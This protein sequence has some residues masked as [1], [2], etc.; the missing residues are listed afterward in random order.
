MDLAL[1]MVGGRSERC[2]Q[3]NSRTSNG[4]DIQSTWLDSLSRRL[5]WARGLM[6]PVRQI[7]VLLWPRVTAFVKVRL[8]C[9]LLLVIAAGALTAL[10]PL[11]L[12]VVVDALVGARRHAA[13]MWLLLG[14]Y[15]LALCFSRVAGSARGLVFARAE[16]RLCRILTENLFAHVM[17]LPLRY[18]LNRRTGAL[19]QTLD[20]GLE[21]LRMTLHH[22]VF[23]YVPVAVE[24]GTALA[25]I[26]RVVPV[27]FVFLFCAALICYLLAFGYSAEKLALA[28]RTACSA[29]ADVA[30][31]MI[32]AVLN[33]EPVKYFSAEALV[34]ERVRRAARRA[35]ADWAAFY[36]R[37]AA[38]GVVVALVFGAFL[39][40]TVLCAA[41]E[42]E[43]GAM[44]IGDF[45]LVNTY[46][47]QVVRPV[48]MMGYA[49]QG[50]SQGMAMLDKLLELLRVPQEAGRSVGGGP[51]GGPVSLEMHDVSVAYH[52]GCKVLSGLSFRLAAGSAL[53]VVGSSGSG[54]T[55]IVRLLMGLLDPE[56]GKVLLDGVS[57]SRMAMT[58]L[59]RAIAVV[60]QDTVLFNESLRYNI[61]FG[62][63][64]ASLEE[65]QGAARVALLHDFIV[66]LPD[67]YDTV[68]GERG[69]KL[70]GGERQRV[71]IAR[72]VLKAPGVYIFDEA[73][74]SL[75][76]RT[77]REILDSLRAISRSNTTIVITHR[78][79]AVVHADEIIVLEKGAIVERGTHRSLL[80]RNGRYATL[81]K[82]QQG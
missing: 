31:E 81:W 10:S 24:L 77:E 44:T 23:T 79:S 52:A 30:A 78:L 1:C 75:D 33:Y 67:G 61:G 12:K 22:L 45:V 6:F 8:L 50:L 71:S 4:R 80:H 36:R 53:G 9:A 43:R 68:V 37:Y 62:R 5:G 41:H 42:V 57:I 16:E 21:G 39:A 40:G 25:V 20:S 59:R 34:E 66:T 51:A 56:K 35:E 70:S 82:A 19:G 32:D 64:E 74:S 58:E 48:E 72:A 73:T 60:P 28:A 3:A 69:V 49:A 18:H 27:P 46:M 76:S 2:S 11:A 7:V 47:L 13:S 14:P 65:I 26:L 55:T 38:N 17:R 15:V 63:A 29:R 54:K